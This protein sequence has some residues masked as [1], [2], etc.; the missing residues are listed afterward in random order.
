MHKEDA[1]RSPTGFPD[2]LDNRCAIIRKLHN[3]IKREPISAERN[4]AK[5]KFLVS[6]IVQPY[7]VFEVERCV[8]LGGLIDCHVV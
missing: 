3:I 8:A 2:E 6:E 5:Q 1:H 7:R 4:A